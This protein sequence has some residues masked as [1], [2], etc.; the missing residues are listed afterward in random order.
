MYA[1]HTP[2]AQPDTSL[3]IFDPFLQIVPTSSEADP[4][5]LATAEFL[6]PIPSS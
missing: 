1:R 3:K 5:H 2:Y 4:A 6:E